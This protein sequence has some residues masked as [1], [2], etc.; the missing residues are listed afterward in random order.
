[1]ADLAAARLAYA[2]ARRR[3]DPESIDVHALVGH[4]MAEFGDDADSDDSRR[5]EANDTGES[6]RRVMTTHP[7]MVD[8]CSLGGVQT[9]LQPRLAV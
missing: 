8:A 7:M 1:M 6:I 2:E 4:V 3:P 9:V 5:R